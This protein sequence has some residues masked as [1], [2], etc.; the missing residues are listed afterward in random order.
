MNITARQFW[1][2]T[3][4]WKVSDAMA[5][6]L[7]GFAGKIGKSGK[8]PRFRFLPTHQKA[9]NFMGEIDAALRTMGEDSADW[10][11]R[12]NRSLGRSTPIDLMRAEGLNG[13]E[14]VLQTLHRSAL[15]S[16]VRSK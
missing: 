1:Q 7:I 15:L 4:R 9:A 2:L 10:L 12:K 13:M 6:E 14:K 8:R 3:A 16:S 11:H 5:L